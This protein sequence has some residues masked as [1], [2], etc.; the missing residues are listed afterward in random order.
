M[1]YSTR[2]KEI[3][4]MFVDVVKYIITIVIIGGLLTDRLTAKIVLF[5]IT[6]SLGFLVGAWFIIP[7]DREEI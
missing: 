4:K 3:G 5:G 7:K 2:R 1:R 6:T